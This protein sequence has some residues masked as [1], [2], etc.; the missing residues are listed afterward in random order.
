[1]K[2]RRATITA[3]IIVLICFFLPWIQVSCGATRET[4]SGLDLARDGSNVLWLIPLL[5]IAVLLIGSASVWK[6]GRTVA[7]VINLI[8]G[9]LSSLLMHNERLKSEDGTGFIRVGM[10][11]WFWL[12]FGSSIAVVIFAVFDLLKRRTST[13]SKP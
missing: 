12:G 5:M 6:R 11:G 3:A 13:D 1:M 9:L 10:T 4:A 7:P 2:S 8:C